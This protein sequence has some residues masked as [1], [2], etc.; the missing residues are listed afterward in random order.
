MMSP[1]T[2]IT[3][4]LL[5]YTIPLLGFVLMIFFGRKLPRQGD[6][7]EVSLI[8]VVLGLALTLLAQKLLYYHDET[9]GLAF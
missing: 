4:A 1:E 9:I 6:W 3:V 8:T 2:L 7:L 5:V